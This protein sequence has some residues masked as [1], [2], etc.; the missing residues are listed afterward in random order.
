MPAAAAMLQREFGFDPRAALNAESLLATDEAILCTFLAWVDT[1]HLDR[2]FQGSFLA[3]PCS[4]CV[5]HTTLGELLDD[6]A[7]PVDAFLHLAYLAQRVDE[8]IQVLV[9]QAGY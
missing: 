8:E 5:P 4:E 6:G 1:G 2:D 9:G 3:W 7:D